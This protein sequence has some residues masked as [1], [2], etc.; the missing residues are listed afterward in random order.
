MAALGGGIRCLWEL[1]ARELEKLVAQEF[2]ELVA[3]EFEELVAR[4]FEELV[5]R[6]FEELVAW[7][8]EEPVVGELEEV[9]I[10]VVVL[11]KMLACFGYVADRALPVEDQTR[12][13]YHRRTITSACRDEARVVDSSQLTE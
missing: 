4:E 7:E 5:A 8:L 10:H 3:R 6:E 11:G 9:R 12:R 13:R 1:V 2:E